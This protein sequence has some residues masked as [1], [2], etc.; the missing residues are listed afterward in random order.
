WMEG[1]CNRSCGRCP[2]IGNTTDVCTDVA[3]DQNSTCAQ[4]AAWG[5]CDEPWMDGYCARTCSRCPVSKQLIDPAASGNTRALMSYLVSECREGVISG[6]EGRAEADYMT[7][8]TGRSPAI[9]GLDLVD[10]SPSR[11]EHGATSDVSDQAIAW[12]QTK[13]G[14]VTLSWHWNAPAD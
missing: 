2:G 8:L 6:Q 12:W 7:Q 5:K 14:I 1:H 3:P 11:V 10:Y 9:L 13:R 4:Q